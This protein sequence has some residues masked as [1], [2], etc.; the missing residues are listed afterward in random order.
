MISWVFFRSENFPD[1]LNYTAKL[2]S[3]SSNDQLLMQDFLTLPFALLLIAAILLCGPIP[4]L[5]YFRNENSRQEPRFYDF[6][7]QFFILAASLIMLAGNTYNPF[8]YFRF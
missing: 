7:V 8:I 3:F 1:A 2:F 6:F 4:S 5:K